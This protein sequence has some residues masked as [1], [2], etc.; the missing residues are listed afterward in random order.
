MMISLQLVPFQ[1][2]VTIFQNFHLDSLTFDIYHML[3]YQL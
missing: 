2:H 3:I 1:L